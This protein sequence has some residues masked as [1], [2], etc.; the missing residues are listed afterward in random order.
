MAPE[1]WNHQCFVG[2][3]YHIV[4]IDVAAKQDMRGAT[5]KASVRAR[6]S[7]GAGG[8]REYKHTPVLDCPSH[9]LTRFSVASVLAPPILARGR[10]RC[11]AVGCAHNTREAII[12]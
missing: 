2:S 11:G 7:V 6:V 1:F 3:Q 5:G 10:G 12:V 9:T 8:L 4:A